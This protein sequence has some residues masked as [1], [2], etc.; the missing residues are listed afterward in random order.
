MAPVGERN[1]RFFLGF[2]IATIFVSGYYSY[3]YYKYAAWQYTRYAK[4][5]RFSENTME[6]IPQKIKI[7]IQYMPVV[8]GTGCALACVCLMLIYFTLQQIRNITLNITQIE[9][10]KIID[11]ELFRSKRGNKE[12]IINIY[13]KGFIGNWI[14]FL[15]PPNIPAHPN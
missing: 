2:L 6:A 4:Y 10:D 15:F 9:H 12:P 1:H 5:T 11:I 8:A 7:V 3:S 13:D 14:E